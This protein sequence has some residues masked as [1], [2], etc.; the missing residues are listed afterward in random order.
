MPITLDTLE[1]NNFELQGSTYTRIF[2]SV[3][4]TAVLHNPRLVESSDMEELSTGKANSKLQANF[5]LHGRW[6]TLTSASFK[7][8]LYICVYMLVP[9]DNGYIK[10][11][12]EQ[13]KC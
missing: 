8:Q 4:N 9:E 11:F 10:T 2:F 7:G 13:P 6:V 5:R 12:T 3:V 1:Q